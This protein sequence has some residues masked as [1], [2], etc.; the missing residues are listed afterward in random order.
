MTFTRLAVSTAALFCLAA[1][2]H[3]QDAAK[4][5]QVGEMTISADDMR[6]PAPDAFSPYAGRTFQ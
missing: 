2:T 4:G 6:S 1:A 5:G 3:A